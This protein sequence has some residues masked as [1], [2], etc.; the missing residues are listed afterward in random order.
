MASLLNIP[1]GGLQFLVIVGSS[2]LVYNYKR[3]G[4]IFALLVLPVLAGC[5][6]PYFRWTFMSN[7]FGF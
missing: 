4:F 6:M 5:G 7:T 2:W 3:K 1:F